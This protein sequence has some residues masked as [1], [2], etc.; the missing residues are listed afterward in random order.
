MQIEN[1]EFVDFWDGWRRLPGHVEIENSANGQHI[2][3]A[4]D[5]LHGEYVAVCGVGSIL[6]IILAGDHSA[7]TT[8]KSAV[9]PAA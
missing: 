3:H 1:V 8:D 9:M 7:P 5:D 4:R 6:T 2:I